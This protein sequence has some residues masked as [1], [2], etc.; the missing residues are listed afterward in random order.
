MTINANPDLVRVLRNLQQS[1]LYRPMTIPYP[2]LSWDATDYS[3]EYLEETYSNTQKTCKI[4]V[5]QTIQGESF[6]E[7]VI[8]LISC[9]FC[10]TFDQEPQS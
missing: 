7:V 10:K 4:F 3:L 5:V 2:N 1:D 8:V 9:R 6:W